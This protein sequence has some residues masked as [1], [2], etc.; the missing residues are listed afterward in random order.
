MIHDG[1][2]TWASWMLM[3]T[4]KLARRSW[5][6]LWWSWRCLLVMGY[7]YPEVSS[8][9]AEL[10]TW[11]RTQ[12][13]NYRFCHPKPGLPVIFPFGGSSLVCQD[14]DG[15]PKTQARGQVLLLLIFFAFRFLN[16]RNAPLGSHT[17]KTE[18]DVFDGS[19]PFWRPNVFKITFRWL[20][21]HIL[22]GWATSYKTTFG[23]NEH[24]AIASVLILKPKGCGTPGTGQKYELPNDLPENGWYI[25]VKNMWWFFNSSQKPSTIHFW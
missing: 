23:E 12:I 3:E 14:F 8:N 7:W 17:Y 2:L 22:G 11:G 18:I 10:F 24:P 19:E 25:N 21:I 6:K 15:E 13:G 9:M 20:K 1:R 16:G 4:G 5:R